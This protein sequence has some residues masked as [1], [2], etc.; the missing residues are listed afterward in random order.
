[1]ILAIVQA[2]MGSTRL[3]G[4][5]MKKVLGKP[6]IE[7]LLERLKL[8]KQVNKILVA[9][10]KGKADDILC[11]YLRLKG[12]DFFRGPGEDVLARYYQAACLHKPEVIV[13]ITADCPLIDYKI[14]DRVVEKF[15]EGNF[16]YV[17]NIM[18]RTYP[19]GQD[20]EVFSFATLEKTCQKTHS[21]FDREHVTPFIQNSGLFRIG[22][23]IA[24][25]DYSYLRWTMDTLEDFENIRNIIKHLSKTG[26][27]FS[28]R[29]ILQYEEHAAWS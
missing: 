21:N 2:R 1:M 13:R 9:I 8:S 24:D 29:E 10:P 22:S 16:D 12:Y 27:Y 25:K 3:P 23:I 18:P 15:L 19:D 11:G 5:V 4:K 6:L 14:V 20:V 28:M 17:S 7:H 26:S